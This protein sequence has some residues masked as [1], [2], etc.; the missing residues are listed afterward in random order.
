[1]QENVYTLIDKIP[2]EK[3][4]DCKGKIMVF[5]SKTGWRIIDQRGV[6]HFIRYFKCTH[7]TYTPDFPRET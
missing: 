7:W 6:D 3:D 2:S 5:D 4:I 1:M